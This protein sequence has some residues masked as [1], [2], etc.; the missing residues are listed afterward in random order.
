MEAGLA[1][2]FLGLDSGACPGAENMALDARLLEEAC[3][4]GAF[5][6]HSYA[7][8]RPTL[9]LGYFQ[10]LEDVAVDASRVDVVTRFTGGGAILHDRE[11]TFSLAVPP[12]HAL[13][14]LDVNDSYLELTR[15]LL[16]WLRGLGLQAEFRGECPSSKPA[17]CF[18]GAACPDIVVKGKKIFGSAQ[19]RKNG[20]ILQHGSLLLDID[21]ELWTAVF[22]P[23]LGS[24][25]TCARAEGLNPALLT[26]EGLKMAYQQAWRV[27]FQPANLGKTEKPQAA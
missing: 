14:R 25:F 7:W 1:M 26:P 12:E 6:L 5:Y 11:L 3:A 16:F 18:A 24:G 21:Q 15:P 23:K 2:E 20:G 8:Q 17:N 13:S 10:K 22:G 4:S 9:S 19:R 27:A